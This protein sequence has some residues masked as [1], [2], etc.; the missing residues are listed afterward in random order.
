MHF[1]RLQLFERGLHQTPQSFGRHRQLAMQD[2][3]RHRQSQRHNIL[4]RFPAGPETGA[5]ELFDRARELHLHG[6]HLRGQAL[7][8]GRFSFFDA[9]AA[10]QLEALLH[11]GGGLRLRPRSRF[12]HMAGLSV[13]A[14]GF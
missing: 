14:D 3:A 7:A 5:G 9:L 8:A 1:A 12:G 4:L 13:T 6:L 2:A 11:I 10:R